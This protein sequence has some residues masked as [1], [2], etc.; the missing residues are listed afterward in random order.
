MGEKFEKERKRQKLE[1][2]VKCKKKEGRMGDK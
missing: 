2:A 1:M